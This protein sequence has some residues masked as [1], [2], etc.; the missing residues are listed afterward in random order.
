MNSLHV[1]EIFCKDVVFKIN[2]KYVYKSIITRMSRIKLNWRITVKRFSNFLLKSDGLL[3]SSQYS[4]KHLTFR[5]GLYTQFCV[6][7]VFYWTV[8]F[9]DLQPL[10]LANSFIYRKRNSILRAGNEIPFVVIQSLSFYLPYMK[11]KRNI[12]F[13][14][15]IL[16]YRYFKKN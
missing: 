12:H 3:Q 14:Y 8:I 11:F 13:N 2:A 1:R 6:I 15:L 9:Y 7:L 5:K 4:Q 16:V 10:S